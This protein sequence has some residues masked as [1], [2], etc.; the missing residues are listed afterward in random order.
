VV[1][2]EEPV[3]DLATARQVIRAVVEARFTITK[4]DLA[5]V[6]R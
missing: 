2:A 5:G 4:P 1:A 6:A 3:F